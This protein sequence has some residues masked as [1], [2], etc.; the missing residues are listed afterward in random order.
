MPLKLLTPPAFIELLARETS[1]RVIPVDASW[2]MPHTRRDAHNE[3]LTI[4]RLNNAVFFDIDVV[5]DPASPYP[6]MLPDLPTFN[7]SMRSLGIRESDVLV[8]YDRAGNFSAPRAAWTFALFGHP[9][10]YLLNSFPKYKQL[11]LPL[12]TAKRTTVSSLPQP[13]DYD[14]HI[15]NRAKEVVVFEELLPLVESNTLRDRYNLVDA[16]SWDRFTGKAPEPRPGLPSGHIAGSQSLPFPSTLAEFGCFDEDSE[17][18]HNRI[19]AALATHQGSLDPAKPTIA[20]CGTG[21]SGVIIKTALELAGVPNVR[22]YDGSWTE[23]VLRGGEV[24]V[25]N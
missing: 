20:M 14:S 7:S 13:S 6:H 9:Q 22:L 3:F 11:G 12:D 21:V 18:V 10:V 15:D 2:Y 23:W 24:K 25:N 5:K 19:T 16:R 17:T 8:V 4:E 1:R